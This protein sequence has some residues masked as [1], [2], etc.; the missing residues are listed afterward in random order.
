[1]APGDTVPDLSQIEEQNVLPVM[2]YH[3]V[4][5]EAAVLMR[6]NSAPRSV[7]EKLGEVFQATTHSSNESSVQN[8]REFLRT[9]TVKTWDRVRPSSSAL[10]GEEYRR[11]WSLLSGE[12]R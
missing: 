12:E 7:A 4:K 9:L 3:G 5:T 1:M 6:M 11:V 8:A 10:S 2:I